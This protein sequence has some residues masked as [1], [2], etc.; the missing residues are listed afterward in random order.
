MYY[1]F[2]GL[3]YLLSLL[4]F[5]LLHLVSD[6]ICQVVYHVIG[7]RKKVVL[8]NLATAFPEKSDRE[9]KKIARAFYRNLIDTF[10]ESSKMVSMSSKELHKRFSADY[11]VINDLYAQGLKVQLHSGH[12]F[13]WEFANHAFADK[14][15]YPFVGVYMPIRNKMFNR[16]F[17]RLRSRFGTKLIAANNFRNEFAAYR[18][19]PYCLA[20]VG[21][22]NPGHP[23]TAYWSEFMGKKAPFPKGPEQGAMKNKTAV[24]FCEF[25]PVRRGYYKG[26]LSLITLDASQMEEGELTRRYISFIEAAIRKRP[27]NYLWSHRRWKHQYRDSYEPLLLNKKNQRKTV[28]TRSNSIAISQQ[29]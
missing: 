15:L 1:F 27:A 9:R 25:F 16:L 4:P 19:A 2:Y 11:S 20:L 21:D 24:V 29:P 8:Q 22:Q 13:N 12:F 6:A 18:D 23:E 10:I 17:Y 26:E 7:Y 5:W 3:F 28:V 14:I